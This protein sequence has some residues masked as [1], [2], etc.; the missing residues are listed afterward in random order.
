MISQI[1]LMLALSLAPLQGTTLLTN[2]SVVQEPSAKIDTS[3]DSERDKTTIRLAPIK[4]AGEVG[5]YRS[6]HMS[7]YFSFPGHTLA[8]PA[9]VDFELQTVIKGRLR[10]DLYVLFVIDGEKIFLSSSRW[11]VKRP[12]PGRVWVGERLVFRMPYETFRRITAARTFAITF[13][14]VEF[15]VGDSERETLRELLTQMKAGL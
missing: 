15:V 7:P 1:T 8:T 10:T 12:V 2:S 11:A 3:Y 13:D 6:V 14:G 4:I 9:I 5:K